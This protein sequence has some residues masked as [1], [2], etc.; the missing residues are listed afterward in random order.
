MN[1]TISATLLVPVLM[2]AASFALFTIVHADERG[3]GESGKG[4]GG[5]VTVQSDSQI[6]IQ[7]GDKTEAEDNNQDNAGTSSDSSSGEDRGKGEEHRS[8]VA[9]I[10][11][12]LQEIAGQ[13]TE[14]SDDVDEI[15]TEQASTSVEAAQR[16]R[17]IESESPFKTFLFGSDFKNIGDLRSTL[18]TTQ[19]HIDRLR[20]AADKVTDPQVKAELNTQIAALQDTASSTRQFID[21]H[22]QAFSLFGWFLKLINR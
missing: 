18:I 12:K 13:D 10:A 17:E 16:M 8:K 19:S 5:D 21:Q 15:A 20:N 6:R 11:H 22:E 2:L 3:Q 1:K 14:I 7:E 9:D 4:S